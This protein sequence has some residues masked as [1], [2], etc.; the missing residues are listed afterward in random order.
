[1]S[2]SR[3]KSIF[4]GAAFSVAAIVAM[5]GPVQAA[6]YN[7]SWDP[8]YGAPLPDLYWKADG[9]F[10]IP[11]ACLASNDGVFSA[12]ACS[13]L[14]I[15]SMKL[16]FY[17]NAGGS[18]GAFLE[19]FLLNDDVTINSY[20]IANHQFAGINTG[21]FKSII[22]TTSQAG[23]GAYA[24]GLG[25]FANTLAQLQYFTPPTEGAI[26]PTGSPPSFCG[27]SKNAGVGTFTP[28]VPEP[29]TYALLAGGLAL[30]G[31]S[32]RRRRT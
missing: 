2:Q 3:A 25:L 30:I 26:C 22:G 18:P 5:V 1:M 20:V 32:V 24:F 28:A 14:D 29:S 16:S 31:F 15:T 27:F 8:A 21:Y 23:G 17:A 12:N 6:V 19:S 9:E 4:F 13:G 10:F 7:G 11:D